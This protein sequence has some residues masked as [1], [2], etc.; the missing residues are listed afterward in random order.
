VTD[1]V[2]ELSL[3]SERLEEQI[4]SKAMMVK[5]IAKGVSS[6]LVPLA[7]VKTALSIHLISSDGARD[8]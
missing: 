7:K 4:V 5:I 2:D 8:V 6:N 3:D 1:L